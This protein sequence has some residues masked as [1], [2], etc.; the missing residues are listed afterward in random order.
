MVVILNYLREYDKALK[1]M[2]RLEK[3]TEKRGISPYAT[4]YIHGYTYLKNGMT[5]NLLQVLTGQ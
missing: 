1:V 5:E 2:I 3:E 4:S